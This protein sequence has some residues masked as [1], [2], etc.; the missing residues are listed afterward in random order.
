[1]KRFGTI[2]S[3]AAAA[4]LSAGVSAQA[5]E[6]VAIHYGDLNLSRSADAKTLLHRFEQASEQ[7]CGGRPMIGNLHAQAIHD[8]CVKEAMDRAVASVRAPLVASLYN[9][10]TVPYRVAGE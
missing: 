4:L 7:V 9:N 1:M 3:L 10:E 5:E 8:A 6:K 2:V